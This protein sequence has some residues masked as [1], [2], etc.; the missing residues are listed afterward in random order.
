MD[1]VIAQFKIMPFWP[2][3]AA[4]GGSYGLTEEAIVTLLIGAI[5]AIISI[6]MLPRVPKAPVALVSRS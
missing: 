2:Q 3:L 5:T 1:V 6:L 4:F